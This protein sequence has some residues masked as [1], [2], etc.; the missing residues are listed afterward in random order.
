MDGEDERNWRDFLFS[1]ICKL[2]KSACMD[3]Q[4]FYFSE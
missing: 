3:V 1:Y 2:V 4:H